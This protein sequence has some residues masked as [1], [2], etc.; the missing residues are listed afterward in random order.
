MVPYI[1]QRRLPL[2]QLFINFTLAAEKNI[3]GNSEQDLVEYQ[4]LQLPTC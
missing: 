2:L 3:P 4:W 1:F